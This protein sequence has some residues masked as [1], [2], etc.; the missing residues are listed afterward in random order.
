VKESSILLGAGVATNNKGLFAIKS[1][2]KGEQMT[3]CWGPFV[4]RRPS[5]KGGKDAN[6]DPVAAPVR[7]IEVEMNIPNQSHVYIK[8]DD[9]RMSAG[10]INDPSLH[11]A[12]FKIKPNCEF[13]ETFAHLDSPDKLIVVVIADIKASKDEPVELWASYNLKEV[14]KKVKVRGARHQPRNARKPKV[15]KN[16]KPPLS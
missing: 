3:L 8:T 9:P 5:P 15:L 13:I 6:G 11:E 7:C 2:K 1:F 4:T 16:K 10:Y 12:T 14:N